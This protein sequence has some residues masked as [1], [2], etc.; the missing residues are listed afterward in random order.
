[1]CNYIK[2]I[3]HLLNNGSL[4]QIMKSYSQSKLSPLI[5]QSNVCNV[6]NDIHITRC[7]TPVECEIYT[8]EQYMHNKD[9]RNVQIVTKHLKPIY[10]LP[11]PSIM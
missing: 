7:G 6:V 8:S 5:T 2:R 11:L 4:C 1:M 3:D 10:T 9:H